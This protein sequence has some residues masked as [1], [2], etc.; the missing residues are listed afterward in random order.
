MLSDPVAPGLTPCIPE[1]F[2]EEKIIDTAEVIQRRWLEEREQW[3]ENVDRIH[4]VLA[5]GKLVLQKTIA[6]HEFPSKSN[7]SSIKIVST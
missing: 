7:E 6:R 1:F 5:S 2:S 4:L 3:L